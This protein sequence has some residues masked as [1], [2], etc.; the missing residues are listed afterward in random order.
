MK[1]RIQSTGG[2]YRDEAARLVSEAA[3]APWET[4]NIVPE[5]PVPAAPP[6]PFIP[7]IMLEEPRRAPLTPEPPRNQNLRDTRPVADDH[8]EDEDDDHAPSL[9]RR[10]A[11]LALLPIYLVVALASVGVVILFAKSVLGL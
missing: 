1:N 5:Q 10:I 11:R 8:D 4:E 7:E 9:I 2:F 6:Q 3:R